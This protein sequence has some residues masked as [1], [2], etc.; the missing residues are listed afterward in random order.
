M[1]NGNGSVIKVKWWALLALLVGLATAA[2]GYA[3]DRVNILEAAVSCR[4]EEHRYERDLDRINEKLD[5][6]DG[7][8][9]DLIQRYRR[10]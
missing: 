9:L 2:I 1:E 3:L 6:I 10:D 8:L 7:R 5:R 4:V